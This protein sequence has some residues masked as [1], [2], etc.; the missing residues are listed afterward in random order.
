VSDGEVIVREG[1]DDRGFYVIAAGEVEVE[2]GGR[3]VASEGA[4]GYFGEV[5]SLRDSPRTA[6]VRA[7]APT[8]LV[9]VPGAE[10]VDALSGD[11]AGYGAAEQ[12]VA[13]RLARAV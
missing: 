8:E 12:V 10:F 3:V 11:E 1:E 6:T 7:S 4:G 2:V 5:A 13:A 9:F